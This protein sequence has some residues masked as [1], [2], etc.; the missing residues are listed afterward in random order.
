MQVKG[1]AVQTI[2]Q[3]V[4]EKFGADAFKNWIDSLPAATKEIFQSQVLSPNWYPLKEAIIDSTKSICDLFYKGKMDGALELGKFS[5]ECS[6]KGI[7]KLFVK[8]GT[9]EFIVGKAGTIFTT[10]YQPSVME[11]SSKGNKTITVSITKFDEP[12]SIIEY[13]IKGWIQRAL[14]ISGAK[15]VD[16]QITKTMTNNAT[17]TDFKITWG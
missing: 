2:P 17:S 15:N 8:L 14:E 11:I 4:K 7:Y 5:A 3:F 10:Y 12:N 9:P 1:T 6:L 13:R 16:V